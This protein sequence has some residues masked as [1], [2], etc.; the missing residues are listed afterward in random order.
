[1]ADFST[2]YPTLRT[3]LGDIGLIPIYSNA[4]LDMCIRVGLLEDAAMQPAG[5]FYYE[6]NGNILPAFPA[7]QTGLVD[8]YRIAIRAALALLR[9]SIGVKQIKTPVTTI[10]R[11]QADVISELKSMLTQ[12]TGSDAVLGGQTDVDAWLYG[13]QKFL[14]KM[15]GGL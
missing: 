2:I 10:T 12:C 13:F 3:C 15:Q 11:N 14:A 1:V 9:P 4:Q 7:G 6:D 8:Q 5:A